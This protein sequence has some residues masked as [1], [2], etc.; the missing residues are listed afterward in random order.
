MSSLELKDI[1][2]PLRVIFKQRVANLIAIGE[3]GTVLFCRKNTS[4]E[5][6]ETYKI[7]EFKSAIFELTP[8]FGTDYKDLEEQIKNIF[9]DGVKKVVLVEYKTT[10][11]SVIEIITKELKWNWAF[12]TDTESQ[13]DIAAL[14][15]EQEKFALTFNQQSDSIYVASLNNPSAVLANEESETITNEKLLPY[16]IGVIAGCPYNKSISYKTFNKLK[17][18]KLPAEIV[19]GQITL[20][21]EEE[22]VRVASPV[23]TLITTDDTFTEDMKSITIAEG[24]QRMKEDFLFAFR[25]GYKGKYKNSYDNQCL[26]LGAG[27]YYIEQLEEIGVLD[28]GYDNRIDIDIEAQRALWK[29]QGKDSDDWDELTVKKTTYKN[30]LL[31]KLDVKFLDAMEGM[32]MTV[33]MF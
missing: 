28:P 7:T 8:D 31:L 22:G 9:G 14:G 32:Q 26:F 2:A 18:V 13:S 20:Y 10:I 16:I 17:S 21:N 12:S 3:K 25:T 6:D 4:L 29:A 5:E 11:A 27:Q 30:L 15:E 23:N 1:M 19:K 33:E 24:M